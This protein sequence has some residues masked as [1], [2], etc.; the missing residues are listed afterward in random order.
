MLQNTYVLDRLIVTLSVEEALEGADR[1]FWLAQYFE[2][3][4]EQRR[5]A[6]HMGENSCFQE[7]EVEY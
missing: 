2:E 6:V 4:V 3:E 1:W 5:E 7:D